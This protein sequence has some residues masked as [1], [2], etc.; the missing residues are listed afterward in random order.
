METKEGKLVR[1]VQAIINKA[2]VLGDEYKG[3]PPKNKL[4]ELDEYIYKLIRGEKIHL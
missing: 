2:V 4:V 3:E 1:Q